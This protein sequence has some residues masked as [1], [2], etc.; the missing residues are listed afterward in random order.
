MINE[1]LKSYKSDNKGSAMITGLV[2][3]TVLMVLCLSLLLISYSLFIS[4]AKS[5]SDLP[6]REMLYSAAEALE[7]EL[8]DFSMEYDADLLLT[9]S[10]GHDFWQYIDNSIWKG[11][12]LSPGT[13]NKYTQQVNAGYWMYYDPLD[14]SGY[15]NDIE[16]CSKYFNLTS[17]GSIKI[18]VQFY[19][20][21]P[22][23]FDGDAS[24]RENKNGTLLN[25]IY[26]MYDNKGNLLVKTEKKYKYSISQSSGGSNSGN[27]GGN[28]SFVPTTIGKDE[29]IPFVNN[30]FGDV[31][32]HFICHSNYSSGC[33]CE[34]NFYNNTNTVITDFSIIIK[35]NNTIRSYGR[36][37]Y[38]L[39][40]TEN[41]INTYLVT[42]KE[43]QYLQPGYNRGF[44]SYNGSEDCLWIPQLLKINDYENNLYSN[45]TTTIIK[46]NRIGEEIVNPGGG[47]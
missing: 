42:P 43:Y 35:T 1:T 38:N 46:W 10:T 4:T 7:H 40:Y 20:E 2:V 29:T 39:L 28:A 32:V 24:K 12:E 47:N 37:Y 11:F 33:T 21:L 5:T 25:A 16:K 6:N 15:H 18:V 19:W 27:N 36:C 9:D 17:I 22:K 31:T 45:N 23:G 3:S 44:F 41:G 30:S 26:R 8:L 13:E 14:T 34:I